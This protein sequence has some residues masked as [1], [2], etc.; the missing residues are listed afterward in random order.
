ML[1]ITACYVVRFILYLVV[2]NRCFPK[3]AVSVLYGGAFIGL[4]IFV[5]IG[6][7]RLQILDIGFR[8]LVCMLELAALLFVASRVGK[9]NLLD[10]WKRRYGWKKI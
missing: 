1:V 4:S 7:E 6:N 8:V 5:G 3:T 10:L 2:A 9:I